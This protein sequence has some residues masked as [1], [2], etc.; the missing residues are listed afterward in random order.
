M[1]IISK[2]IKLAVKLLKK[3]GI[4]AYPTESSYALGCD[5]TNEEAKRKICR[6]KR[7]PVGK[8]MTFI[9]NSI[10][11]AEKYAILE[12]SEK[13]AARNLMPGR[14]TLVCKGRNG[15]EFAFRIPSNKIAF[16]LAK[17]FGGPITATSA[18]LS[19]KEPVFS[20]K[21]LIKLYSGKIDMVLDGGNLPRRRPSTVADVFSGINIRRRG[22][23]SRRMLEGVL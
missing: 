8:Q 16:N 21:N 11:V 23:V 6:L 4:I 18:N 1:T 17:T 19:G 10:G 13:N 22:P 5:G 9:V 2:D 7:R 3:G 12:K 14:L 20:I 15:G